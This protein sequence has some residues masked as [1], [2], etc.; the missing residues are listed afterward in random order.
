VAHADY[1][2]CQ[3]RKSRPFLL[4]AL[5]WRRINAQPAKAN[6]SLLSV[7]IVLSAALGGKL[8]NSGSLMIFVRGKG[9]LIEEDR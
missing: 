8:R 3:A 6:P 2:A 9:P 7:P 4:N 1:F 5:S